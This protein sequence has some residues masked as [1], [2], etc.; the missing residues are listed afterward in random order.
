MSADS[1]L[2]LRTTIP[3][4]VVALLLLPAGA[5]AVCPNSAELNEQAL[6]NVH[7]C[8]AAFRDWFRPYFNFQSDHWDG[9]WGWTSC[10]ATQAFPKM[11]N[12]AYLITYGLQDSSMGP[13]HSNADY[14]RWAGGG[15]HDFRYEPEDDYGEYA[16]SFTGVFRTN[17][18]EM[19]CPSFNGYTAG[20]R[21][22]V[23]LHEATHI[24][25]GGTFD[26]WKHQSNPPGSNCTSNCSDDWF[27]HFFNAYPYGSLAGHKHSM[28]QIQI[29]YNCD[30]AEFGQAWV[31]VSS[32]DA[33]RVEANSYL[34]N[35]IRNSPGWTCGQPRP[36]PAGSTNPFTYSSARDQYLACWGIAGQISSNCTDISDLNDRQ[37]CFGLSTGSQSPFSTMTD[38]NLQLA[39]YGMSV[40][41]NYPSNCNDITDAGMKDFCYSVSSWGSSGSCSGVTSPSEKA[42]CQALTYRNSSYCASITN[43][44][45]KW[46]CYGTSSRTNS[47]CANIVQ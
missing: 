40:A 8:S 30:L 1:K 20:V 46:F 33:A 25:Y 44:N 5:G 43:A 2:L 41:P 42:L 4:W 18:V 19:K 11:W 22:G 38:R 35:R 31:P 23:M 36:L 3:A 12:A 17:R 34:V 32:K 21:A 15:Q 28:T 14:Y 9:G 47:Y 26:V 29:E 6:W 27:F 39:C 24:I 7:N 45:D 37:L 10:D 16:T 13:W